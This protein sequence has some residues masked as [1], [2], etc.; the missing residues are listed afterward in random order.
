MTT[1]KLT[2]QAREL[3]A[4]VSRSPRFAGSMPEGAA[5]RICRIELE[6]LGFACREIDFDYSQWPGLWGPQVAAGAQLVTILIVATMA[7]NGDP[8]TALALGGVLFAALMV[9]S[10][11]MRRSGILGLPFLRSRGTDLE[12]SRGQP[13]IWLVAHLDTKSQTVPMLYRIASALALNLLTLAAF[14]A[15]LL[16]VAGNQGVRSYWLLMSLAAGMAA[17]P[18]LL[19]MVRNDSPGAV[20]NG[21]GVAAV[22]LAARQIPRERALGVL[23]TS[24]EELGLAGARA[25]AETAPAESA[26]VNCDTV[27]DSGVWL[28]MHTGAKPELSTRAATTARGLGLKLRTRRLIPCIL[29]DSIAFSD[30]GLEA[31]TISRGSLSTLARIHT[32]RDNTTA[33]TGS[34]I[35]DAA[36]LLAALTME[37]G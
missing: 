29:A 12:A 24:A 30:R 13:S 14:V 15:V 10:R 17:L 19:C 6:R 32:R 7:R 9:V 11:M 3:L 23:I 8:V 37:P 26:L 27:D 18:S 16:Q 1:A 5:R 25:W 28:C 31:V 34:G 20:D 22:L 21:S 36:A 35:A 33:L 4:Q 2:G